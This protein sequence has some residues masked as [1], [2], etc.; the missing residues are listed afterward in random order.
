MTDPYQQ[1]LHFYNQNQLE[2][3]LKT[4]HE[5]L[6]NPETQA[7][8]YFIAGLVARKNGDNAQA[9]KDFQSSVDRAPQ[10][11][12]ALNNLGN[13]LCDLGKLD[14][15]K[16]CFERAINA[17]PNWALAYS[18]LGNVFTKLGQ[19][20]EAIVFFLKALDRDPNFF[21][22]H[23]NC[24]NSYLSLGDYT[25]ALVF[26]ER[27]AALSPTNAEV[28]QNL[29]ACLQKLG[30]SDE[31]MAV[32][33][34]TLG[35]APHMAQANFQMAQLCLQN[36]EFEQAKHFFNN[37]LKSCPDHELTRFF[38]E[39]LNDGS[40]PPPPPSGHVAGLFNDYAENF[41]NHLT[42]DLEYKIPEKIAARVQNFFS[43][44]KAGKALD[45]GCGT[46][47]CGKAIKPYCEN[48]TGIDVAEKMLKIAKATDVYDELL[49]GDLVSSLKQLGDTFDLVVAGDV[50]IYVGELSG[51]FSEVSRK[52]KPNGRFIFSVEREETGT[53]YT[54]KPTGCYAHTKTYLE[55]L[56]QKNNLKLIA[57]DETAI[58]K[59]KTKSVPGY[60]VVVGK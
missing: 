13:A 35:M 58:R 29:A 8:G 45:L 10:N 27:A 49:L 18:G 40:N 26:F 23:Y 15:A 7:A 41:D 39:G 31:A 44:R 19:H 43:V 32:L 25:T 57:C 2:D 20:R 5:L 33:Q 6:K 11:E 17:K 56:I 59:G 24:G 50:F 37:V 1:A 14:E 51:V 4:A 52:L 30:K 28:Q 36:E 47:L 22:A 46:G 60:L 16:S 9:A 54:L 3:A 34:K 48:L 53:H 38:L 42:K 55:N 12:L 21:I